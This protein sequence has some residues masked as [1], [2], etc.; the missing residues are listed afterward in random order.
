MLPTDTTNGFSTSGGVRRQINGGGD[1]EARCR[2]RV[3][4][5]WGDDDNGEELRVQM[6][7]VGGEGAVRWW[8]TKPKEGAIEVEAEAGWR[9]EGEAPPRPCFQ[10]MEV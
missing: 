8:G 2:V 5:Y 1:S 3:R 7:S 10:P 4:V 9:K 6:G